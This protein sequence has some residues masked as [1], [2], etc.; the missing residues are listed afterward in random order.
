MHNISNS[1]QSAGGAP[2]KSE[3][4]SDFLPRT[5]TPSQ[6]KGAGWYHSY[7]IEADFFPPWPSS[8]ASA[9]GAIHTDSAIAVTSTFILLILVGQHRLLFVFLYISFVA[10]AAQVRRATYVVRRIYRIFSIH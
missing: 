6:P 5:P 3:L 2:A 10:F 1:S 4:A 8:S 7:A 9:D